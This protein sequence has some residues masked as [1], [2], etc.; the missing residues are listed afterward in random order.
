MT[1]QAL[2]CHDPPKIMPHMR[3]AE[4]Y[5]SLGRIEGFYKYLDVSKAKTL[6]PVP[7]AAQAA[8]D[9]EGYV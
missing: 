6:N 1:A 5:K 3:N 2:Q 9:L 7:P 8:Q 4:T